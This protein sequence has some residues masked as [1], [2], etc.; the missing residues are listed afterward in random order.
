M[1][2]LVFIHD[3]HASHNLAI[4]IEPGERKMYERFAT[5]HGYQVAV[6]KP[7]NPTCDNCAYMTI[8][9]TGGG[10]HRHCDLIGF[11]IPDNE[12][13]PSCDLHSAISKFERMM[14]EAARRNKKGG[15]K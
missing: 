11:C 15:G 6:R 14:T 4:N 7:K 8:R 12:Q 10:N 5:K 1:I 3:C 13:S 2:T 9:K